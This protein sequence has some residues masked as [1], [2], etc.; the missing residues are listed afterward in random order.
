VYKVHGIKPIIIYS[1]GK[2]VQFDGRKVCVG[3]V[4]TSS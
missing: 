1:T 3:S 4:L 2:K